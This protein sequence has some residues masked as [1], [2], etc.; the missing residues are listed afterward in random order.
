M[1]K[2]LAISCLMLIGSLLYTY[3]FWHQGMGLNTLLFSIFA[4]GASWWRWPECRQRIPV[5]LAMAATLLTAIMTAWHHS[6]L[7]STAHVISFLT[8][9]GLLQKEEIRFLAFGF[10]LGLASLLEAPIAIFRSIQESIPGKS[11]WKNALR[12]AQLSLVPAGL[13]LVFATIYYNA[14][15]KF[16]R[17]LDFLWEY[18]ALSFLRELDFF[19]AFAFIRGLLV[20]GALLGA[21]YFAAYLFRLEQFFPENLKRIRRKNWLIRP[22]I[23]SLKQE[24]RAGIITFSLLNILLF[25]LNIG[26]LRYVWVAYGQAS[27]QELSQ[28]VHEGTYL[29]LLAI[30]LAI[31]AVLWYFRGNINFYPRNE[32]LPVLVYAWLAQNAMLALS[33]GLRNWQYVAH[34]GLAYKRL[35]VFWFLLLALFGLY[36][37]YLKVRYR[38]GLGYLM[39]LNGLACFASLV[40]ACTVNWDIAITRYNIRWPAAEGID[41]RFLLHEVSDKNLYLLYENRKRLLAKGNLGATELNTALESKRSSFGTRV[42]GQGWPSWNYAD[43]CNK[44]RVH[45]SCNDTK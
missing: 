27:P 25:L 34:Y 6:V 13:G 12:W 4:I 7:A 42:C 36:S 33:V 8:M 9:I 32:G 35:G 30:V 31:G 20:T 39:R 45:Q 19:Q 2:A 11:R 37:M 1:K 17:M 3:L 29:L 16:A 22:G 44:K 24:H 28:Y 41:T 5:L 10:A 38:K 23:L 43:T 21:S 26:D 40:L 15:P 18:L 14:S